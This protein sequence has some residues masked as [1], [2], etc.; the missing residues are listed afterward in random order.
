MID[1][2]YSDNFLFWS[3]VFIFSVFLGSFIYGFFVKY[4]ENFNEDIITFFVVFGGIDLATILFYIAG[5]AEGTR[6]KTEEAFVCFMLA[7]FVGTICMITPICI[8]LVLLISKIFTS[9]GLVVGLVV[10]YIA[11]WIFKKITLALK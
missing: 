4:M 7:M 6:D 10:K 8:G 9:L 1:T 2:I 3:V 11:N 5:A